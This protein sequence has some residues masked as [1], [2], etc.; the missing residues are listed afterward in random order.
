MIQPYI[1][2]DMTFVGCPSR[3]GSVKKVGPVTDQVWYIRP[4]GAWID[5]DD[6]EIL[7]DIKEDVWCF[8]TESY[9][10]I[11][12]VFYLNPSEDQVRGFLNG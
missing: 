1:V 4:G 9:I 10:N 12:T 2:N 5:A 7:T 3:L 11:N 8:R 6:A